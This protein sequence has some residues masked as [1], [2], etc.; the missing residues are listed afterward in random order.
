MSSIRAEAVR[1]GAEVVFR[2]VLARAPQG[3]DL[4]RRQLE[5]LLGQ[6]G[7]D[8]A[9]D[10]GAE[11]AEVESTVG[12]QDDA[13]D[14]DNF[15]DEEELAG[16]FLLRPAGAGPGANPASDG[17]EP[18]ASGS[19]PP[20]DPSAIAAAAAEEALRRFRVTPEVADVQ[21]R[22][23]HAFIARS[24]RGLISPKKRYSSLGDAQSPLPLPR[25]DS[26]ISAMMSPSL[27][28]TPGLTVIQLVV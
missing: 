16:H 6:L 21:Q 23:F 1:L 12:V 7:R 18:N 27:R 10:E 8:P 15:L 11:D 20:A 9:D 5:Y 22:R 4:V 25:Q 24:C 17:S 13:D 28:Y 2:D 19:Q 26:V 14:G 3:D